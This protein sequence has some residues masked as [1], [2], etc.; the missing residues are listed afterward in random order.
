MERVGLLRTIRATSLQNKIGRGAIRDGKLAAKAYD[1]AQ[2]L[3][4]YALD[5]ES[6]ATREKGGKKK[7]KKQLPPEWWK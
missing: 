2:R 1:L 7:T 3:R 6:A 5:L 4:Q